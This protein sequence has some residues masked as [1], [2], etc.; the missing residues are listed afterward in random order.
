MKTKS[1]RTGLAIALSFCTVV[2]LLTVYL[3]LTS[4]ACAPGRNTAKALAE[5]TH[6]PAQPSDIVVEWNQQAVAL[7]LAATSA[8]V[9]QMRLMAIFHLSMHDAVN[10]ITGEYQTYL[11]PPGPPEN[12]SPEAAA[13]AAAHYALKNLFPGNDAAL[14]SHYLSSLAGH[15]LSESNPGIA[16]GESAAAA[17]LAVR[18][19]DHS[20]EAQFSY[21][22]PNAGQPGVWVRLNNAPAQL[23]GWGN[24]TPFVLRSSG[25][26]LP[27][28][29]PALDSEK[30]A[31]D[32]NEIKQIGISVGSTR[33]TEQSQIAL[34][35]RASP[36]AIWNNVAIQL[37]PTREFNLSDEARLFGLLYL[38]VA[39]S[40]IACWKA[41]YTYNFWRPQ[42]AIRNGD[43]DGNDLTVQDSTWLPF[44]ATPPHPEYPSGHA[45]NSSAMAQVLA[46]AFGDTPD[47][48]VEVTLTG[49]TRH[50]NSLSEAV[51]EVI[52]ARVYSGIHFRNSDEAGARLGRQVAQFVGHHA[53]QKC[54]KQC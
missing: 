20:A 45:T 19:A 50:W 51:E 14:Y 47:V 7:T 39:D 41:K 36:L 34:F 46:S 29:P 18:A 26:F 6:L 52:D 32:Y 2:S 44:I 4:A 24:V 13:I 12:A 10:G 38:T 16:F 28:A 49:I 35:W 54:N 15:G 43:T 37:L 30:Y 48:P 33:S 11:S 17:I 22:A 31:K 9:Q 8:A 23:P 25:Q 53:L 27:E 3:S 42:F 1:V 5:P 40:S 21:D